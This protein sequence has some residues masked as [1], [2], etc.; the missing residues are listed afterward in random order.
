[1]PTAIILENA[2]S[3][4]WLPEYFQKDIYLFTLGLLGARFLAQYL[5][6]TLTLGALED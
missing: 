4:Y 3:S 5:L 6:F 1:M 2:T